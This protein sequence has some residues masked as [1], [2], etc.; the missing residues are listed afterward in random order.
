MERRC[1]RIADA[2]NCGPQDVSVAVAPPPRFEERDLVLGV[3]LRRRVSAKQDGTPFLE[4][5]YERPP[6]K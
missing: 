2:L 5:V 3:L 1:A 6:I 4:G